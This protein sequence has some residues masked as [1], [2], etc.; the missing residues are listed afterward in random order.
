[1]R[2]DIYRLRQ[3]WN[4]FKCPIMVGVQAKQKLDGAPSDAI[5]MPGMYD[6]EESASIAQR[7]DRVITLWMPKMTHVVGTEITIGKTPFTV[8]ENM[9]FIKI[10]K[11]RGRLPSGLSW[12]CLIDF[13]TNTIK[14]MPL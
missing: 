11:Q 14:P 5:Q 4:Y 7:A 8:L 13:E 12:P 6:G 9:L 10:A 2:E 3:M 1:V